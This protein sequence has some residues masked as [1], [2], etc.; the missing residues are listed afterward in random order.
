[1]RYVK[2]LATRGARMMFVGAT[3][4]VSAVSNAA[5]AQSIAIA[6]DP[7]FGYLPLSA[8]G[9][10][11]AIA[12]VGDNTSH[13]FDLPSFL[14][15]GQSYSSVS[16]SSN[17]YVVVGG[18]DASSANNQ[19][20]PSST[21]PD[22]VLAPF[23]TDLTPGA[24]GRLLT[25]LLTDGVGTWIVLEWENMQMA[26]NASLLNSFQMWIGVDGVEDIT[27]MYGDMAGSGGTPYTVGA[28]NVDGS[29]GGLWSY[30]GTG[31]PS[32]VSDFGLRV[33]SSGSPNVLQVPE[34]GAFALL[35]VAVALMFASAQRRV[36]ARRNRSLAR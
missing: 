22:N 17:G 11:G 28:E 2:P 9:G 19:A 13:T 36:N 25:N 6:P 34:P 15:G 4:F 27:F 7:G 3:L 35:A 29:V 8:F 31:E 12:G 1:M 20:L 5:G 24:S 32:P 21:T 10:T 14:W 30:N 18:G 33:S 23:W 26:G 16:M